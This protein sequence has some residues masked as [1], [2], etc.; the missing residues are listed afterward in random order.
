MVAGAQSRSACAQTEPRVVAAAA[1]DQGVRALAA[2]DFNSAAESFE[3][4]NRSVPSAQAVIQA[5]RA[6][7]S[8]QT[9]PHL[10]RA[11]TLAVALLTSYPADTRI[12]SYAYRIIDELSPA[13]ARV[14]VRCQGCDLSVDET[15]APHNVF[16]P[17]GAHAVVASWGERVVRREIRVSPGQT[18]PV[19]LSP[20]LTPLV[21]APALTVSAP[22]T[23]PAVSAA[24]APPTVTAP[25][26][27]AITPPAPGVDAPPRAR[28]LS[29]ALF[30][31]S[32]VATA[33]IGG[34]LA[35][36]ALNTLDGRDAYVQNPT[37][38][39]LDDGRSREL[40]TNVLVGATAAMA[41]TTILIAGFT[42][43]RSAP[44]RPVAALA[45]GAGVLGLEGNF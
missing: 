17:P 39:G 41:V 12:T 25:P 36:S 23:P 9:P 13:L 44:A 11:A 20:P 29:P 24:S 1:Y 37:Q 22:P 43:W 28:G 21:P 27:E 2:G 19:E 7:R 18:L 4:A 33:G 6:H 14:Q 42:R 8:A 3:A 5:I 26:P 34:A 16:L 38:A 32:L 30:A 15:A 31:V 45:P 10:A 40:R 35:W